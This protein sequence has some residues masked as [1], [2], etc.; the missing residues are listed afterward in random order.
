LE[1]YNINIDVGSSY[2][3]EIAHFLTT[4]NIEFMSRTRKIVPK[5]ELDFYIPEHKIAIEFNG[6]YWHSDQIV[7]DDY[8]YKKWYKCNEAGICLVMINE[9]EWNESDRAIKTFILDLCKITQEEDAEELVIANVKPSLANTFCQNHDIKKSPAATSLAFGAFDEGELVGVITFRRQHGT[10]QMELTRFC[11]LGKKYTGLFEKFLKSALHEIS[12]PIVT[13]VA[14][15][16]DAGFIEES[17]A[18]PDFRYVKR[19]KT[20]HKSGF[21]KAKLA[22]QGHD[23][24]GKTEKVIMEELG[25]FRIYDCGKIRFVLNP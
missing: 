5:C 21:S 24:T 4:N 8:H 12:D 11:T 22:Q 9:D 20:Y 15:L 14:L 19:N 25:Y 18:K 13:F 6:L 2:E 17:A 1:K 7:S 23:I 3:R 10:G 16:K